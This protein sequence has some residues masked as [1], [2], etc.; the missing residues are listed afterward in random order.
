MCVCGYRS[1]YV[2]VYVYVYACVCMCEC[3][4]MSAYVCGC[5]YMATPRRQQLRVPID[6]VLSFR[7]D[8][9]LCLPQIA[10]CCLDEKKGVRNCTVLLTPKNTDPPVFPDASGGDTSAAHAALDHVKNARIVH[11][12]LSST[13]VSEAIARMPTPCRVIVSGPAAFNN[14]A[15]TMLK[16]LLDEDHVTIL[17]A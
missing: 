9:V 10:E 2:Y 3:L 16:G 7:A 15:R 14:C 8:D 4:C 5:R 11:S 13:L 6:V 1:M 12:R 17:S